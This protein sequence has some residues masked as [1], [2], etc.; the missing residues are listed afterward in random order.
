MSER[1]VEVEQIVNRNLIRNNNLHLPGDLRT[2]GQNNNKTQRVN[3]FMPRTTATTAA[4]TTTTTMN[5]NATITATKAKSVSST[6]AAPDGIA[7][8]TAGNIRNALDLAMEKPI[9]DWAING[10]FP[11]ELAMAISIVV[12]TFEHKKP[13]DTSQPLPSTTTFRDAYA[14][15][16]QVFK[17][18]TCM[19]TF[20]RDMNTNAPPSP[21]YHSVSGESF[22]YLDWKLI[23]PS[24]PLCCYRCNCQTVTSPLQHMR[25][26]F[27]RSKTMFNLWDGSGRP[28]NAICMNYKCGTCNTTYAAN[29]GALLAMLPPHIREIYPVLPIYAQGGFHLTRDVSEDLREQMVTYANGDVVSKR[30]Y[31]KLCLHYTNKIETYLSQEPNKDFISETSFIADVFPPSGKTLRSLFLEA[32]K[33]PLT[34]YGYSHSQRHKRELQSV[35]IPLGD[36]VAVDWTFQVLKNYKGLQGKYAMFTMNKGSTKEMVLSLIVPSTAVKEVSHA[37]Q[38]MAES[39][40]CEPSALYSDITPS[41][42]IFWKTIL[43]SCVEIKLGMFHIQHRIVETLDSKCT[44]YWIGLV[45]LKKCFYRYNSED[46]DNLMLALK[47]GTFSADQKKMTDG[48]IV[49]LRQ[50]K[51]WKARCDPYLRKETLPR[52]TTQHELQTW[53][54]KYESSKDS[55]GRPLFSQHTKKI[56]MEQIKKVEHATDP[57]GLG[58]YTKV[59]PPKKSPHGL[60]TWQSNRPESALEKSHE[61]LAHFAN[62]GMRPELADIITMRGICEKNVVCR[63]RHHINGKR[64]QG[65]DDSHT[66]VHFADI[67]RFYDHSLL[68]HLNERAKELQLSKPFAHTTPINED[69][70][71]VFLS[72]YFQA[73]QVR[74][75]GR[76]KNP[77][78][79]YCNCSS[80]PPIAQVLPQTAAPLTSPTAAPPTPPVALPEIAGPQAPMVP[81]PQTM[82]PPV[83]LALM[84]PPPMYQHVPAD[85]CNAQFPFYCTKYWNYLATKAK[86][87][88]VMGCP[89][90]DDGCRCRRGGSSARSAWL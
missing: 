76:Q 14:K 50:S 31:K 42:H 21:S 22:I 82:S 6:A 15:Y 39:R 55:S 30:L 65:E 32:Q 37:L 58:M 18:G 38:Q 25:T 49:E 61:A 26:N 88:R 41:N 83:A 19:F 48:D 67:P 77:K 8:V 60:P 86:G 1:T 69:N 59:P 89:P 5:I 45:E 9:P 84:L 85:A 13:S 4:S 51:R 47:D 54:N 24:T 35:D 72:E 73:Q 79:P 74:N 78:T 52:S 87:Q 23:S 43:K 90:H 33:T 80:C 40:A 17:P 56:A 29:E 70:G 10:S 12:K 2:G 71:E 62:T 44:L 36:I 16:H 57:V 68:L 3:Y 53:I 63:W 66:P 11:T 64:L 46:F 20:P 81:Q 75:K 28:I 7:A 27:S 34:S